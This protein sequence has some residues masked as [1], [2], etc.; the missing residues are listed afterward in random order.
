MKFAGIVAAAVVVAAQVCM[1]AVIWDWFVARAVELGREQR[2]GVAFGLTVHYGAI[3][4]GPVSFFG[5]CLSV[6]AR[7]ERIRWLVLL[8]A[9]CLWGWWTVPALPEYPI[10]GTVYVLLGA[11]L[12]MIGSGF[13]LPFVQG[14]LHGMGWRAAR[15]AAK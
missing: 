7:A 15:W 3:L 9:A 8:S 2:G 12:L 10:R 11:V 6:F 4:F 13:V 1:F 14:V 5:S